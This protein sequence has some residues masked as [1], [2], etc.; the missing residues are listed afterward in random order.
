MHNSTITKYRNDQHHNYSCELESVKDS[1]DTTIESHQISFV[2]IDV[3]FVE[4]TCSK[5]ADNKF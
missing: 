1:V 4:T 3:S 2:S 5:P